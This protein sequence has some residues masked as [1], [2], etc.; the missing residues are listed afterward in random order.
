VFGRNSEICLCMF[1]CFYCFASRKR[2]HLWTCFTTLKNGFYDNTS[3]KELNLLCYK[4]R[5]S[6]NLDKTTCFVVFYNYNRYQLHYMNCIVQLV[7]DISPQ[8]LLWRRFFYVGY[9]WP[10]MNWNVM[11]NV[12]PMICA[13]EPIIIYTKHG[14]VDYYFT[15]RTFLKMGIGFHLTHQIDEL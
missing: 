13:K 8:T 9:W 6:T 7:E 12:K 15:L 10:T 11:N 1:I 14:Q 5:N 4:M 3:L 2:V